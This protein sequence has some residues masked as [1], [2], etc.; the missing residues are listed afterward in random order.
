MDGDVIRNILDLELIVMTA[1]HVWSGYRYVVGADAYVK[2]NKIYILD[3][4]KL[5]SLCMDQ[6]QIL[7]EIVFGTSTIAS[8]IQKYNLPLESLSKLVL[9]I[10][11]A[12]SSKVTSIKEVMMNNYISD[13]LTI[14]GSEVKGLI[15]TA[16]LFSI[17]KNL[18]KDK[19]FYD[20]MKWLIEEIQQNCEKILKEKKLIKYLL[21]GEIISLKRRKPMK[22]QYDLMHFLQVTDPYDCK[23]KSIIDSIVTIHKDDPKKIIGETYIETIPSNSVYRYTIIIT[24]PV[25]R[26]KVLKNVSSGMLDKISLDYMLNRYTKILDLNNILSSLKRFSEELLEY[27][28]GI[29]EGFEGKEYDLSIVDEIKEWLT[30]VKEGNDVF[31]LKIGY[32]G[33]HYSKTVYLALPD[34]LR[35]LLKQVMTQCRGKL[36]DDVSYRVLGSYYHQDKL[37]P[38]AWVKLKIKRVR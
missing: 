13:R 1:V 10:N 35:R 32:G 34:D 6:R 19:D 27:E 3:P 5:V 2:D 20:Q 18:I 16:I 38:F 28:I 8:I 26:D 17:V 33:G 31:Y 4:D 14:P 24:N 22:N 25:S 11:S 7:D 36:W 30:E 29:L 12:L 23:Y 21:S 9:E 15:R 37:I